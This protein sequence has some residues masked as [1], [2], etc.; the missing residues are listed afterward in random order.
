[1]SL[2]TITL[3]SKYLG[4]SDLGMGFSKADEAT[5]SMDGEVCGTVRL[6]IRTEDE[7]RIIVDLL[8]KPG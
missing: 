8:S 2:V 4:A 6:V 3:P 5:V 1:M 7:V